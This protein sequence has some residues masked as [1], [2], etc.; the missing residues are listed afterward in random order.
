[1]IETVDEALD[2][3]FKNYPQDKIIDIYRGLKDYCEA[4]DIKGEAKDLFFFGQGMR[5][6][7]EI[8]LHQTEEAEH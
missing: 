2:A 7:V 4:H 6:G 8:M 1:M 5:C 3:F